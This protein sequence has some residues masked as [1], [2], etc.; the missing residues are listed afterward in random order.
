MYEG[1]KPCV[2]IWQPRRC[3]LAPG[4]QALA[5]LRTGQSKSRPVFWIVQLHSGQLL[6]VQHAGVGNTAP[7]SVDRL[8]GSN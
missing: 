2:E 4:V 3:F 5:V 1:R 6:I 7:E 8:T